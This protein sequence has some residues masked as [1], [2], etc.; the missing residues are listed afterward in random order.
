MARLERIESV[1][2][3]D[4]DDKVIELREAY[5]ITAAV[6]NIRCHLIDRTLSETHL[7]YALFEDED[8]V[9]SP[10]FMVDPSVDLGSYHDEEAAIARCQEHH[11]SI[12][13]SL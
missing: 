6:W 13:G 1:N 2:V 9:I 3:A 8:M 4:Y 7:R 5:G 11:D 12:Y 10:Q